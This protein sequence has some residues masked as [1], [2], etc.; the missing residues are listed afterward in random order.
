M[1]TLQLKPHL[2][3][4]TATLRLPRSNLYVPSMILSMLESTLV[5][6]LANLESAPQPGG[7]E[8]AWDL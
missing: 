8:K 5:K 6:L 7:I 3:D 1:R 2:H 4:G